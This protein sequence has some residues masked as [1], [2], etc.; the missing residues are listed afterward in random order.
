MNNIKYCI[1]DYKMEQYNIMILHKVQK[2]VPKS[3]K[4][5]TSLSLI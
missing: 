4:L 5:K 1:I 3:I 2:K